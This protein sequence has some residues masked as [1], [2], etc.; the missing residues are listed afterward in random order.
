MSLRTVAAGPS[1]FFS[2][3]LVMNISLQRS[4]PLVLK[5]R[6]L[7]AGVLLLVGAIACHAGRT[8]RPQP[9]LVDRYLILAAELEESKQQNLYDAVRQLR[10]FWLTRG[11]RGRTGENTISIYV[12]DQL[13]GTLPALRRLSVLGTER[14]RYM[15]AT[16]A[17]TRFGQVNLG[18]A[19]ILVETAGR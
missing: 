3:S 12:D 17:Q 11:V 5:M 10:S 16:E 19:A 9:G 18:R 1:F 14:V 13:V 4:G 8:S 2:T 15:S 7:V 6:R